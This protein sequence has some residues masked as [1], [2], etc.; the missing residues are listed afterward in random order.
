MDNMLTVC[1][2][3]TLLPKLTGISVELL[4]RLTMAMESPTP[5]CSQSPVPSL[6]ACRLFLTSSSLP[7][8]R[9]TEDPS[10]SLMSRVPSTLP[11]PSRTCSLLFFRPEI[12]HASPSNP[13]R[14]AE[15]SLPCSPATPAFLEPV[16]RARSLHSRLLRKL[17][18]PVTLLDQSLKSVTISGHN[19]E[20]GKDNHL[21][22]L[23][24][25]RRVL[26][27]MSLDPLT[28]S[29]VSTAI[30][31][32]PSFKVFVMLEYLSR[33]LSSHLLDMMWVFDK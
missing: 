5:R 10:T 1:S 11:Q 19:T 14:P 13:R 3:F 18:P 28:S 16:Q 21:I 22:N 32:A 17:R 33:C 25:K 23:S 7:T 9:P 29:H 2:S 6:S 24:A 4:V 27:L 30:A 12:L 15:R 31:R 8:T 26:K 20:R